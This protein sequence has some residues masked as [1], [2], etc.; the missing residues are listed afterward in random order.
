LLN[1]LSQIAWQVFRKYGVSPGGYKVHPISTGGIGNKKS[2]K[3]RRLPYPG[4]GEKLHLG[5]QLSIKYGIG[6]NPEI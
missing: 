5:V 1:N 3:V 4:V 6:L 2:L